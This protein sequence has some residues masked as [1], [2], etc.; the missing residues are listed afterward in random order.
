MSHA[1]RIVFSS[2]VG[3][4]NCYVEKVSLDVI[5]PLTTRLAKSFVQKAF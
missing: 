2:V 4:F 3:D 5:M 1:H